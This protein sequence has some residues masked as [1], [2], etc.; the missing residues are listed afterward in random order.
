MAKRT[1]VSLNEIANEVLTV[2]IAYILSHLEEDSKKKVKELAEK[3]VQDVE[4]KNLLWEDKHLSEI[5]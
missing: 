2:G 4:L 3:V 5:C 1:G